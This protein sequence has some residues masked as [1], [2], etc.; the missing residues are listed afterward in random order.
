LHA[1]NRK[2]AE[3]SSS[4]CIF[5][6][7]IV[8][9]RRQIRRD[10]HLDCL[11]LLLNDSSDNSS[12]TWANPP[13]FKPPCSLGEQTVHSRCSGPGQEVKIYAYHSPC[14]ARHRECYSAIT[15]KPCFISSY[16]LD[17]R[18]AAGFQHVSLLYRRA[19]LSRE[20]KCIA[21]VNMVCDTQRAGHDSY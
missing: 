16:A 7:I 9:T 6:K 15:S 11:E 21:F 18:R 19:S 20:R 10:D 13:P 1:E 3:F 8:T 12:S 17:K 2:S 5:T 4:L 14:P